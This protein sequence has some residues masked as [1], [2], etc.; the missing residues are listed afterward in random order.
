ML[1]SV[2]QVNEAQ[3]QVLFRKMQR[4]FERKLTGRTM[5]VWGL[6]FKPG[7]DD[8]REASSLVLLDRLLAAG[9]IVRKHDPVAMRNVRA[10]YGD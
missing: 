5:T 3:K 6:A 7:T 9:A 2:D 1:R 10:L 8:V 4:H